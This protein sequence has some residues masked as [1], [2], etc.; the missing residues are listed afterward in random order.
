MEID[1]FEHG[2]A[3]EII[4]VEVVSGVEETL[5]ALTVNSRETTRSLR[6]KILEALTQRGWSD[7]IRISPDSKI[8]ITSR[9]RRVGLCLQTGNMSRFYA[10]LLKLQTLY[11]SGAVRAGI[12]LIPSRR[13][14]KRIGSNIAHFSRFVEEL[15]VFAKTVTI[16]LLV[17][18]FERS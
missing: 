16:P 12:Y 9:L 6:S 17:F 14:A 10:D 5:R 1:T 8:T 18:G 2:N 13:E 11:V 7:Q 4:S 3:K 15:Q